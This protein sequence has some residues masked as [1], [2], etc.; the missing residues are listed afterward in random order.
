[1]RQL[2]WRKD[3]Q[4]ANFSSRSGAPVSLLVMHYTGMQSASAALS[5]LCETA[6]KVS[7][8]YA[9]D[10]Q[11]AVYPLVD[12][13]QSAWHAG[14]SFWRGHRNVNDIS[15]GIEIVNPGHE[16]G[17][18]AFPQAQM[19]AVAA[20]SKD[21]FSRHSIAPHNVVAHSDIAPQRKED[22]GELF[23][24]KW[25]A[26]QGI[27]VWAEG[28]HTE[29]TAVLALSDNGE[30]VRKMQQALRDY[31]YDI[32]ANGIFD[33]ATQKVVIA[34]QRHF[35]PRDIGGKWDGECMKILEKLAVS[36]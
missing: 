25:L 19:E 15:I 36:I 32:G 26:Q 17:Y 2:V 16:W 12:E 7:A 13:A 22:P 27:G 8:H 18:R 1:M 30:A 21:I 24:W 33:D 10:E 29:K 31:G 20:L 9:V 5:R 11:G 34:F 4:S 28:G 3:F 23:D 14:L 6:A 35:R